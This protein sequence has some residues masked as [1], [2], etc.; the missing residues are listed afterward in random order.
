M[1]THKKQLVFLLDYMNEFIDAW[2][3]KIN[4]FDTWLPSAVKK[5]KTQRTTQYRIVTKRSK[6]CRYCQR[7]FNE[8]AAPTDP[9]KKTKDHVVPLSKGGHDKKENRVYCCYE[10]NRWKNN[11]SL[12]V[13]LK[14]VK[15]SRSLL[16]KARSYTA[17][18]LNLIIQNIQSVLREIEKIKQQCERI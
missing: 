17:K 9:L 15:R 5:K 12:E 8:K 13:W 6:L 16:T 3:K 14:L 4:T 11:H 1:L 7:L 10:C 2:P 18:E